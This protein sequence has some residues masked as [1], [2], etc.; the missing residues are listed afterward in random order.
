[1]SPPVY[2]L[3]II[4]ILA[5]L[6]CLSRL[7]AQTY[8]DPKNRFSRAQE[9]YADHNFNR[10]LTLMSREKERIW[11]DTA[12][13][14]FRHRLLLSANDYQA[15]LA[16][17]IS[18]LEL[19]P[20]N[21]IYHRAAARSY[22]GL[23]QMENAIYHFDR[24]FQLG[25]LPEDSL[26]LA[27]VVGL[28]KYFMN[29]EAFDIDS[30]PFNTYGREEIAI[31]N[32]KWL[33]YTSNKPYQVGGKIWSQRGIHKHTRFLYLIYKDRNKKWKDPVP[34]GAAWKGIEKDDRPLLVYQDS[35]L[36]FV[37]SGQNEKEVRTMN[38]KSK[39]W[40][41]RKCDLFP[42]PPSTHS[43]N[44]S[45][46]GD[47]LVFSAP[48]PSD[49]GVND[50]YFSRMSNGAWS[51]PVRLGDHINSPGH[52]VTPF[53]HSNGRLYF[54]SNGHVGFGGL[55]VF[56]AMPS[57]TGWGSPVNM[58]N[59]IST[60]RDDFYYWSEEKDSLGFLIS[61]RNEN[62][63][64]FDI[65]NLTRLEPRFDDCDTVILNSL[66]F[67]FSSEGYPVDTTVIEVVYHLGDGVIRKG[68]DLHHCYREYG[69]Y[70]LQIHFVDRFSGE[71]VFQ[72]QKVA[73]KVTAPES[74]EL[75]STPLVETG[76]EVSLTDSIN[77]PRDG[78][79]YSHYWFSG[80]GQKYRDS[81]FRHAYQAPGKYLAK[82]AWEAEDTL[83][84]KKTKQC[85]C[86]EIEVRDSLL[87]WRYFDDPQRDHRI[88]LGWTY[89]PAPLDAVY[90]NGLL[91]VEQYQEG[92]R[93]LYL[94]GMPGNS[95]SLEHL[96][97]PIRKKGFPNAKLVLFEEGRPVLR[98]QDLNYRLPLPE[99]LA[100]PAQDRKDFPFD[101][102]RIH[103][104]IEG[105]R[106]LPKHRLHLQGAIEFMK[107]AP[108][109]ELVVIGYPEPFL[110]LDEGK[111]KVSLRLEALKA[112]ATELGYPSDRITFKEFEDYTHPEIP[113]S[114]PNWVHRQF[115]FIWHHNPN[116]T[117]H[118]ALWKK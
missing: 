118:T 91:E 79:K 113:S 44:L 99:E 94:W 114:W 68:T 83:T 17:A 16:D 38:L 10:A 72:S 90:F 109:W 39:W 15:A 32:G 111:E 117:N 116:R 20:D 59:P 88:L 27:F 57:D 65:Y 100:L 108:E 56:Y 107:Q 54:S 34:L 49:P 19:H 63:Q 75:T 51:P 80:D 28:N 61:N 46:G 103:F 85:F 9:L 30:L 115:D 81:T 106:P 74:R 102:D 58:E 78:R 95:S 64:D 18:L 35:L 96:V 87:Y 14:H 36:V 2:Q 112:T 31:T 21:H 101:L 43:M 53:I 60:Q 77:M 76:M 62:P 70:Q 105:W 110:P 1:M 24:C 29:P 71:R 8:P 73:I 97:E 98:E 26:Q 41:V 104:E 25:E 66:C 33:V 92:N 6:T 82:H 23:F 13:T 37:H 50:L 93:Y 5:C 40:E 69:S 89:A 12:R 45:P 3:P 42:I 52:E 7:D 67:D 47:T 86:Q 84:G 11:G 22:L 48:S 4:C 55:D